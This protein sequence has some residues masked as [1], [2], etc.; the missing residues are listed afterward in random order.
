MI[1][2]VLTPPGERQPKRRTRRD[3]K[4]RFKVAVVEQLDVVMGCPELAVASDHLARRVWREIEA[5]DLHEVE[6]QY[7]SLGR[8]GHEPRRVLAVMVYGSLTKLHSSTQMARAT[9]T[10]VAM[11]LLSGGHVIPASTIRRFRSRFG[12][13]FARALEQT[14]KLGV[15]RGLVDCQDLA[16]DAMRLRANAS[17]AAVRTEKRSKQRLQE[18]EQV[19]AS[20]LSEEQRAAHDAKV[21]KHTDALRECSE[22]GRT[23]IVV[24]NRE[25]ALMKFPSGAGLPGHRVTVTAS[26]MKHRFVVGVLIDADA[27]DA[28][29]LPSA[30]EEARRVLAFAG[31][32]NEQRLQ[33][34]ADAGYWNEPTL[35]YAAD[36]RAKID[37]LISDKGDESRGKYFGRDRFVIHDDRS[38]TCPSGA[39]MDG[40]YPHHSGRTKWQGRECGECP[41][42]PQCT[43]A[44]GPR[45]FTAHFELERAR[46][47]MRERLAQPGARERYNRRIATVEPVFAYVQE[48]MGYRRALPQKPEAVVAEV[49]LKLLAHN[50]GRLAASRALLCVYFELAW[51]AEGA[52]TAEIAPP[53]EFRSG[54]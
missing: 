38:A 41:L 13:F 1:D 10:D 53:N 19:D 12:S 40:P 31:V 21:K 54:L 17:T 44:K 26:S 43:S 45:E 4:P 42:K 39:K 3:P 5:L 16:V 29:K 47:E 51:D 15:E 30:I 48:H 24:T 28:A 2:A 7:S 22:R 34:A 6:S 52:L 49:M 25:A 8:R 35:R 50:I 18:L 14:V 32:T 11:R 9:E 23:S 36:N 33:V 27:S 37:I 20:K 46:D